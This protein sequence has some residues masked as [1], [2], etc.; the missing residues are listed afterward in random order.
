MNGPSL[1]VTLAITILIIIPVIVVSV[2]DV[3]TDYEIFI[4]ASHIPQTMIQGTIQ[5]NKL[6]NDS[7][8]ELPARPEYE[9]CYFRAFDIIQNGTVLTPGQVLKDN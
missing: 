9:A 4:R 7:R 8:R 5:M 1:R 3:G 2:W 6:I